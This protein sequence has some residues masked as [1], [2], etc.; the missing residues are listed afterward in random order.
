MNNNKMPDE[1]KISAFGI[2][3]IFILEGYALYQG[4]DGTMFGV[5]S[6]TV[7]GII[8]WV[9]KDY[10]QKTKRRRRK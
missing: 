1:L 3:A 9:F 10:H 4:V 5:S 8:G 2:L 7:G 6:A